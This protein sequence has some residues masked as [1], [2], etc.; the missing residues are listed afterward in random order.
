M[1]TIY[2]R[3]HAVT[4][5]EEALKRSIHFVKFTALV[6]SA[7][8]MLVVLIVIIREYTKFI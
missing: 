1:L 6:R 4:A 5:E 3:I 2:V 8:W 7:L